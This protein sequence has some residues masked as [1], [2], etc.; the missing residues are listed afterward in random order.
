VVR[1]IED[2]SNRDDAIASVR[3]LVSDL[4]RG[5]RRQ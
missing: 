5:L 2:A 4:S 1:A 3:Q